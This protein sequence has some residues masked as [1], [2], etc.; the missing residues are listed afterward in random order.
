MPLDISWLAVRGASAVCSTV[1]RR[2]RHVPCGFGELLCVSHLRAS[3]SP[4]V[5]GF[6]RGLGEAGSG[7]E[8]GSR[9]KS[10]WQSHVSYSSHENAPT[11]RGRGADIKQS[12]SVAQMQPEA[13]TRTGPGAW[14]HRGPLA[15]ADRARAQ[16][17]PGAC[18]VPVDASRGSGLMQVKSWWKAAGLEPASTRLAGLTP[19]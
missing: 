8:G 15:P 16:E 18:R 14:K 19:R 6:S 3:T 9:R 13:A 2:L 7:D 1:C 12:S 17:Q 5:S 11:K 4:A 10:A